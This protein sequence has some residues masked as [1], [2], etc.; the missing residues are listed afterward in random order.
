MQ[1]TTSYRAI[2]RK[3]A[4]RWRWTCAA[5]RSCIQTISNR[6]LFLPDRLPRIHSR[7]FQTRS[8]SLPKLNLNLSVSLS[9]SLSLFLQSFFFSSFLLFA[10]LFVSVALLCKAFAFRRDYLLPVSLF[11]HAFTDFHS[12]V[13]PMLT[14]AFLS[15]LLLRSSLFFWFLVHEVRFLIV[16]F[17]LSQC[18]VKFSCSWFLVY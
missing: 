14:W 11:V 3:F 2:R 8:V 16:S 6:D 5:R 17:S 7:F 4:Q 13:I 9:S 12:R 1:N 10:A 18:S 15:L